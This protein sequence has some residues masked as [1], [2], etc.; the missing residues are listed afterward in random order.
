MM[1]ELDFV[2]PEETDLQGKTKLV[3]IYDI[4]AMRRSQNEMFQ[5]KHFPTEFFFQIWK[6]RITKNDT[7]KQ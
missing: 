6:D 4:P 5:Q 1:K 2:V 7:K 3:A